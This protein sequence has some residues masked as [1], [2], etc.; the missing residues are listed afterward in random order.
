MAQEVGF[1]EDTCKCYSEG[2][3]VVCCISGDKWRV[4]VDIGRK[5][6]VLPDSTIM[7]TMKERGLVASGTN[8]DEVH[9]TVDILNELAKKGLIET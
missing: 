7:M 4:E 9:N 8:R 6:S 5:C 1:F 2:P 3:F